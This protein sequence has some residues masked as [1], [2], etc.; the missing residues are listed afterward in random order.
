MTSLIVF[1]LAAYVLYNAVNLVNLLIF[2]KNHGCRITNI[3][4][5]YLFI[6]YLIPVTLIILIVTHQ[7]SIP[8]FLGKIRIF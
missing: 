8:Q 4:F 3:K 5:G 7:L 6:H 1:L 2:A